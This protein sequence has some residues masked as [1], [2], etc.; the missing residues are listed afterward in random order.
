MKYRLTEKIGSGGM[1]EVFRAIGEGPEG[2]ERPFVIKRIH[3]RLSDA[4]DFVRM[5]VDEAMISARL[6]HPNI[7]Q[8]F[9]FAYQDGGYYIVME[10]VDGTDMAQLLRRL[11]RRREVPPPGFVAEVG[12]QACRGLEFA[13]TLTGADGKPLGIV[14]RDV[15][16]PNIMVAWNGVVKIV[17]F[18]IARAVQELRTNLSDKGM[19]KG[20]ISYIAPELLTGQQADARCDIFSLGVVLHEL[21][22]GQRLFVGENDLETLQKVRE[23]AVEP[24]S[25]RNP[26]VKPALDRVV[27]RALARDPEKRFQTAREMGDELEAVVVR[28]RYSTRVFAK[29]ARELLP[30]REDPTEAAAGGFGQKEAEIGVS[31]PVPARPSAPKLPPVPR[32]VP[33]SPSAPIFAAPAPS[34]SPSRAPRWVWVA[35]GTPALAALALLVVLLARPSPAPT[36]PVAVAAAPAPPPSWTVKVALDSIPQ[37]A[38]VASVPEQGSE[39]KRFG[40]TPVLLELPRG[41]KPV[42]LLLTKAGFAPVTFR[43]IPYQ[44][45]DVVAPLERLTAPVVARATV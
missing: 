40:E 19:V 18:G 39:G 25:K 21:L 35:A 45:K 6:L 23:L 29:K 4:P 15:T 34:P 10:P 20:K 13:H 41:S 1:A 12:R 43:V 44:D 3:P 27:M 8:V 37:G 14:H 24:P 2:F 31:A 26:G 11:E 22:C 36:P 7:V 32:A 38:M 5:F 17:D 28:E 30:E 42:E 16:P 33:T 9:D